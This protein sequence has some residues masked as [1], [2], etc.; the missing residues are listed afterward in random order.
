MNAEIIVR[1]K[2]FRCNVI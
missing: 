2:R 1:D